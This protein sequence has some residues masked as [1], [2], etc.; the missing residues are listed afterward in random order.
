MLHSLGKLFLALVII[1][2]TIGGVWWADG[3]GFLD[4]PEW[5]LA[6]SRMKLFRKDVKVHDGVAVIL[7][8]EASLRAMNPVVGRWPWPRSVHADVIDFISLGKPRL[9]V[10]DILFTEDDRYGPENDRR[11]A[12][13]G[14]GA[15]NVVHSMQLLFDV[16]D[17]I[18][19]NLLNQPLPEWFAERFALKAEIS[20]LARSTFRSVGVGK[21]NN[22][23][24]PVDLVAES[25]LAVGAVDFDP[26]PDG[27]FRRTSLGRGYE[28]RAYPVL[29][30]APLVAGNRVVKI[31]EGGFT[32]G[33]TAF[34]L[35]DTGRYL[36][37][38]CGQY[39]EYSMSGVLASAQKLMRGEAEGL[40]VDPAEF[41]DKIVFIGSSAVG[42]EDLKAT[43]LDPKTPGVYI[44]A[45]ILSNYLNR[46][47]IKVE[48]KWVGMA[49][50]AAFSA[51]CVFSV[52][53]TGHMT[54]QFGAPLLLWVGYTVTCFLAYGQ[55]R[56]L[57]MTVPTLALMLSTIVA[58]V[59][60]GV[61]EGRA[62]RKVRKMF[63]LYVSPEVLSAVVE[64]VDDAQDVAAGREE[65]ISILFSD[66]RSFTN[67]SEKLPA[68]RVV[69]MLNVYF[70]EMVEAIFRHRGTV[71]KFIG[72]AI[73]C[74]WGAPIRTAD[75]EKAAVQAALEMI[76]GLEKVNSE[77][78]RRGF[79][80]LAIGVGINT[81]EAVLG[82]IGSAKKINYTVIGDSV[83]LASRLEGVTKTYGAPIIISEF[84]YAGLKGEIPCA[85]VDVVAVKGK[86]EP[87]RLYR[88]LVGV[89][90]TPEE[91]AA[92]RETER[93][94]EEAFGLY[95]AR[96]W[97]EAVALY[98]TLPEHK[99]IDEIVRRCEEYEGEEPDDDWDGVLVMK[100]K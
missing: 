60:Y 96:R 97:R 24:V 79:T 38:F 6:D 85:V 67:I 40:L 3:E 50:A 13:A 91:L 4:R 2:A 71:D 29:S 20:P 46:D 36:V 25:S 68:K 11:L 99:S 70:T 27:V 89:S 49:L 62:R 43:P 33:D 30:I 66:I 69:E 92:A 100:T 12:E 7:V 23:Y 55:N 26:D 15:G 94:C 9:I 21:P 74:F 76:A 42:V 57:P 16:P 75:H 44:H 90:P 77:L 78:A 98:R 37:N 86:A 83:N 32:V 80:P 8:D 58:F 19:K 64:Q 61:S 93:K 18:N 88:P 17:E 48:E 1:A 51:I 84:T 95:L 47:F 31:G 53:Y 5:M 10:F 65:R 54:F 87:I 52:L 22:A 35:D 34:P 45:S 14:G 59:F 81:G 56:L 63:S 41:R 39:G 72:D 82:N 28:G 73:M